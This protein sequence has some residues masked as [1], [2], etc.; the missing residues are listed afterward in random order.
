[1]SS[2]KPNIFT[3]P[4]AN[5]GVRSS[6]Q[7]TRLRIIA[8][9]PRS[10]GLNFLPNQQI[11]RDRAAQLMAVGAE[12]RLPAIIE[13]RL[14]LPPVR[15]FDG[16]V[17]DDATLTDFAAHALVTVPT[18]VAGA[19]LLRP[20][21]IMTT[22]KVMKAVGI[23]QIRPPTAEPHMPVSHILASFQP[24]NGSWTGC[25]VRP[26]WCQARHNDEE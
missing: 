19:P 21:N 17:G 4:P 26:I 12:L 7:P 8:K 11:P 20:T 6:P 18:S 13:S 5:V 2:A 15:F 22:H 14:V 16:C 25:R 10:G 1:V 3:A 24:R 23:I 9:S